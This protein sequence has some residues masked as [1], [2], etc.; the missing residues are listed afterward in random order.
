M[1]YQ[2]MVCVYVPVYMHTYTSV[3]CS[4]KGL[5]GSVIV[6]WGGGEMKVLWSDGI[7]FNV[8]KGH[9][10]TGMISP[11]EIKLHWR[12]GM[13]R[14]YYGFD[15]LKVYYIKCKYNSIKEFNLW[16]GY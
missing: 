8:A 1:A 4:S 9:Y 3:N 16:N 5:G 15:N 2:P 12:N 14:G 13:G 11:G 10:Y 7:M 6:G